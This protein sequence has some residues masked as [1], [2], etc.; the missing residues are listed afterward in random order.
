MVKKAQVKGFK[1]VVASLFL[2]V[3]DLHYHMP[4]EYQNLALKS[5]LQDTNAAAVGECLTQPMVLLWPV[6]RK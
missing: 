6:N 2:T 4:S 1:M 5:S 3:L